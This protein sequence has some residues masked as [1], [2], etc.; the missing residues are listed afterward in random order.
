MPASMTA[1]AERDPCK[2]LGCMFGD[3]RG[4]LGAAALAAMALKN[5]GQN[6]A[7]L[8]ALDPK[9]GESVLEIGCGPGMGVR[10]ALKRVGRAGFVAGVDQSATAA[11]F[12]AHA[13]HDA[14]R[15]GRAV[16]MRADAADLPFREHLFDRAFAV[17]SFQFW[18]DPARALREIARVLA[19]GGRLVVTQRAS[20]LDNPTT[21]A[22]AAAGMERIAQAGALLKTQGWR[23]IDERCVPD[24]AR[25]LAV[26]IVAEAPR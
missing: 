1:G 8:D 16:I 11:H 4:L 5:G 26:S 14:V 2:G 22:G 13:V 23:M 21:F 12:A 15:Q 10:A 24:G 25:L 18:P 9:P 17:N 7:A 19:P 3:P 20:S 6:K